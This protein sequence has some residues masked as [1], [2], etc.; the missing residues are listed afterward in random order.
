M[1]EAAQEQTE[2]TKRTVWFALAANLSIAIAKALGGA[3]SGSSAM[4]AEAAHSLADTTNQVFLRISLS[5]AER[6][7]DER[8]PFGYGQERF[9][10]AFLAAV[11]IFVA[12]SL[13]SIFEGV[14]RLTAPPKEGGGIAIPLIVLGLAFVAEGISLLRAIRQTRAEARERGVPF[15]RYIRESRD[16]TAKTVVFEDSAAIVG[17]LLAAAGV[18]L[19]HVTGA[20]VFDASASIAIGVLLA[21]VALTL[22]RDVKGLLLGEAALPEERERMLEVLEGHEHVDHV[23]ELRTMALAPHALLVAVRLDLSDGLDS[24]GVERLADELDAKLREAVPEVAEVFIDPTSPS[25]S[26]R[27]AHLQPA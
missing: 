9:F 19:D 23:D 21:L 26:Q 15:A 4:L 6:G 8:H 2:Q 25:D 14:E 22:G 11:F 10:W 24:D 16:P 20:H 18:T 12:G 7:S 3:A 13:F 27:R 1:G 17:V 5:R